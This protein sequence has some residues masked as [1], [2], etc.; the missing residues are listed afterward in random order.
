MVENLDSYKD[1]APGAAGW[2]LD[3]QDL[4]WVIPYHTGAIRYFQEAGVWTDETEAHN[5]SLI[6]RQELLATA[7]STLDHEAA[8]EGDAFAAAW[9]KTRSEALVAAD[10]PVV[11]D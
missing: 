10:L 3:V 4:M 7:W 5:Q 2:A 1:A 11:F 9:M 6:A 8:G